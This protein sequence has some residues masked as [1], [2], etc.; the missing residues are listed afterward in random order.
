MT[1]PCPMQDGQGR[2]RSVGDRA[3]Q[4][5]FSWAS[6]FPLTGPWGALRVHKGQLVTHSL[7][8]EMSNLELV[9]VSEHNCRRDVMPAV[10]QS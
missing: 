8:L 10:S 6:A 2:A 4:R 3:S 5:P 9:Q 7:D 1:D